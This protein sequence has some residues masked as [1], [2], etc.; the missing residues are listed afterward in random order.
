M[1]A[2][3]V[4]VGDKL[5]PSVDELYRAFGAWKIAWALVRAIRKQR[6]IAK[7]L[8]HLSDRM[9][10]DIGLPEREDVLARADIFC[11][12]S[13]SDL[14]VV[15]GLGSLVAGVDAEPSPMIYHRTGQS[16]Q[17]EDEPVQPG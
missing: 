4:F 10:Q 12:I 15:F 11:G 16:L 9:L 5:N 6:G 1:Q 17:L 2:T 13:G 7:Q 8:A 14:C 3:Q